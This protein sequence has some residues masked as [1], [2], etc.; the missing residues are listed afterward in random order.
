MSDITYT[1][2]P[3]AELNNINYNE[4]RQS[5]AATVDIHIDG[6]EFIVSWDGDTPPSISA[7]TPALTEY[8]KEQLKPV[9]ASKVWEGTETQFE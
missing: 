7:I 4:V 8:T 9:I 5:S 1:I 3:I 6:T 2:V